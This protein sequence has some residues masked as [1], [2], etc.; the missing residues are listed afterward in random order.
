[1]NIEITD[2]ITLNCDEKYIVCSKIEYE[3]KNYLYLVNS[4]NNQD[5][6]FAMEKQKD[7]KL[8]ITEI[9]D[10]QL[11]QTLLPLLFEEAKHILKEFEEQ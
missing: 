3:N 5:I 11:I 2:I 6:K 9:E 8:F 1:M 10:E 7:N 4:I